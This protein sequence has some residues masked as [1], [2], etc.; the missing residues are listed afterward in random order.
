MQIQ[1]ETRRAE[2][3]GK[4]EIGGGYHPLIR[5]TLNSRDHQKRPASGSGPRAERW[6][7]RAIWV[8][9]RGWKH[10]KDGSPSNPGLML[11]SSYFSVAHTAAWSVTCLGPGQR[12]EQATVPGGSLW[13]R[14]VRK[15]HSCGL[16][17]FSTGCT[18]QQGSLFCYS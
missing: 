15:Q 1:R 13:G 6:G 9:L 11:I 17:E 12:P 7:E 2:K 14:E 8:R 10:M 5:K 18:A 4:L 16:Q 3:V